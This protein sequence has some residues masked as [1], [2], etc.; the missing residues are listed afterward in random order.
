MATIFSS[1]YSFAG[2]WRAVVMESV[3]IDGEVE[4][5]STSSDTPS[6]DSTDTTGGETTTDN[7]GNET[8][9][10]QDGTS[11][12]SQTATTDNTNTATTA[13]KTS[14]T[15]TGPT[16]VK[17]KG[18][19][20][21]KTDQ[22]S[23]QTTDD[24]DD[25]NN[26]S[27][28]SQTESEDTSNSTTSSS[29]STGAAGARLYIPALHRNFM[30]FKNM[31]SLTDGLLDT[32]D[33]GMFITASGD[34]L[35]TKITD[36]PVAQLCNWKYR[37]ELQVGE[38]V[39]VTFENGN[40]Q[41][42]V[43]LG[44]LGSTVKMWAGTGSGTATGYAVGSGDIKNNFPYFCQ[45]DERWKSVQYGGNTVAT[46]GCGPTSGAMIICSYGTATDPGKMAEK[47]TSYM[48]SRQTT[49]GGTCF[50]AMCKEFGLE[51][52]NSQNVDDAYNAV[53]NNIPVV[54]NPQG[55]C[56]FTQNGHYIVLCGIKDDKFLVND[57][58]HPDFEGRTW[59]KEQIAACCSNKGH[60]GYWI[61]SK[62]GKGSI[63][64]NYAVA[65][66][67][68]KEAKASSYGNGEAGTGSKAGWK[69]TNIY[70]RKGYGVAIPRYCIKESSYY[71]ATWTAE[72]YP[73]FVNGYGT[74]VEI[75]NKSNNK[76]ITAIVD[77]CGAF[78][79]HGSTRDKAVAI[80]LQPNCQKALGIW[81][82]TID[83]QYRVIGHWNDD[84]TKGDGPYHA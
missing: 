79:K 71:N 62:G 68:W 81:G 65:S 70:T 4:T 10:L 83:I 12:D 76:T 13:T 18:E 67:D 51:Y 42:P 52:K 24:T 19:T 60:D 48:G 72:D 55:P 31:E 69:G 59:S 16:S 38:V 43:I 30:P 45:W 82:T 58:N 61:I 53:K 6:S 64:G 2:I 56:D 78:G 73:E 5:T 80:D 66:G 84:P 21:Q 36:Y 47:F 44:D 9:N 37:W 25:S 34:S 57:P 41:H 63:G 28:D 54:A 17:G 49:V 74:I 50:P 20:Q 8:E 29:T 15:A 46:S 7:D 32:D 23:D 33:E 26:Q 40:S 77:D 14:S 3:H 35:R 11:K 39:W 27:T 22:T 75:R 1:N